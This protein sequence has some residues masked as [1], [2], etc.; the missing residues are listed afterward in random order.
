VTV[1]PLAETGQRRVNWHLVAFG[2]LFVLYVLL[3]LGVIFRTPILNLDTDVVDLRLR[4]RYPEWKTFVDHY[5]IL[6]QRGP[7]TLLFLPAFVWVAWRDRS[8][9]PLLLLGVA[10][11]I[12]NLSVGVV[13]L[14]TGRLGPRATHLVHDVFVGGNIFPSGHVSNAVVLYGLLAWISVKHRK[15]M[16]AL[17]VFLSVTIGLGAV[18]VGFHWFSDVM[19]G[20]LAGGLV[21]MALPW[22]MPSAE[23][24]LDAVIRAVRRSLPG[25]KRAPLPRRQAA[26]TVARHRTQ[27]TTTPVSA[28]ARSQSLRATMTSCDAREDSTRRGDQRTSPI[29]FGP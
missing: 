4:H 29:P 21:L 20:W 27:G 16:I 6:G 19:G 1:E 18:Y 8:P 11:V 22:V 26:R 12:L 9:R 17:A 10:L 28:S 5:I 23:R 3:T 14:A 7:A 25:A 13:K 2:V 15:H 24:A